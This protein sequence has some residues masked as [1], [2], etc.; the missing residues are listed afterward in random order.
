MAPNK[1]VLLD[2]EFHFGIGF[3]SELLENTGMGLEEIGTKMDSGDVSV[4]RYLLY[5]SRLYA[6]KRKRQQPDFDLYDIDDLIDENGGVL[7]SFVKSFVTALFESLQKDV[8]EDAT[9]KKVTK[10]EK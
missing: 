1:I 5:Y 9:K 6:V 8:P 7:G 4:Y 10:A 2:K 3:L